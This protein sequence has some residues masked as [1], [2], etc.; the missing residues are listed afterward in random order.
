MDQDLWQSLTEQSH[1]AE[2]TTTDCGWM[3]LK[4]MHHLLSVCRSTVKLRMWAKSLRPSQSVRPMEM[5]HHTPGHVRS[6][7]NDNF[8]GTVHSFLREEILNHG[9]KRGEWW[10]DGFHCQAWT[11]NMMLQLQANKFDTRRTKNLHIPF[12]YTLL[13][14]FTIYC[15]N[16]CEPYCDLNKNDYIISMYHNNSA[17]KSA[18][19][20]ECSWF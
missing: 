3:L 5:H 1:N 7:C 12:L 15:T 18:L 20:Y 14:A 9:L 4:Q 13:A 8:K 11:I 6:W 10:E 16:Y 17:G 19:H 2:A